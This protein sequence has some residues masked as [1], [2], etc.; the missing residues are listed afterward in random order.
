MVVMLNKSSLNQDFKF[1]CREDW[2]IIC[3]HISLTSCS[4]KWVVASRRAVDKSSE[5]A[6]RRRVRQ[7][8]PYGAAPMVV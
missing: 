2:L 5:A 3:L 4:R 1:T 6:T 7:R 8:S